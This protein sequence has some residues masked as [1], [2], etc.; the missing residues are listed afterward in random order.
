MPDSERRAWELVLARIEADLVSG[1]LVP[2]DHLPPERALATELGVGR[3]SVREAVRVL[4]V[5]GLVRTQTGSGPTAGAV[6]V[7]LPS[8]GMSVLLRLQVAAKGFAVNDVVR[9][10][11]I[12]EQSVATELAGAADPPLATA[13]ALLD[14]MDVAA[15]SAEFLALDTRFH[16]ALAEA[17][18]NSVV[19]AVMAGLRDA[20]ERYVVAGSATL[21]DWPATSSRLRSE[22]R[23]LVAAI[24]VHDRDAAARIV[25]DHITG[26]YAE[27]Q[28]SEIPTR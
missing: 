14:G 24:R 5:L 13:D 7:S 26:Y 22:H 25:T 16:T 2:G 19:A 6:V 4:E 3:S 15:D 12:L 9:T 17:T 28:L 20:V 8:G 10:R 23:A 11:L 21:P 1:R 27:T 18:G